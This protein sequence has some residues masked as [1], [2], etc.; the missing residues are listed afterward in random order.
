ML[1][2]IYT[3]RFKRDTKKLEKKHVDYGQL[4]EVIRLI[5]E[6]SKNSQ[7]ELKRRHQMHKLKGDWKGSLECHV[8]N[9]GDW[10]LVWCVKDG[11]AYLQRT[12][13]HDEIFQRCQ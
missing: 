12:G 10:L 11:K 5:M 9:V 2:V 4:R 3:P 13:T 1:H 7:K 8:S 6:D